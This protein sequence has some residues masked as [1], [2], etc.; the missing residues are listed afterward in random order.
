MNLSQEQTNYLLG[1]GYTLELIEEEGVFGVQAESTFHGRPI[2]DCA[3]CIG[4]PVY[5]ISGEPIGVQTR[6]LERKKYRFHQL[7][8]TE[9][10]P[11]VFGTEKDWNLLW[12]TGKMILTEGAFDRVALKRAAPDRAIF[13]RMSKG[14]PNQLRSLIRRYVTHLWTAFDNDE[15]GEEAVETTELKLKGRVDVNNL[16][17]PF[18]DPALMLE[19]RGPKPLRETL[20]AQ[21]KA[22]EI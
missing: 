13:A 7:R 22:T 14:A 3:G 17:F 10:L 20:L 9:H 5:S 12:T 21:L 16:Q 1:R 2:K 8:H 6:E 11:L 18:K 19:K 15:A 4:W